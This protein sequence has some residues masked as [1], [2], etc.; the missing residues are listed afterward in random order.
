MNLFEKL[1][2]EHKL[3]LSTEQYLLNFGAMNMKTALEPYKNSIEGQGLRPTIGGI[4]RTY[5]CFDLRFRD[6]SHVKWTVKYDPDNLQQ[7]LAVSEDESLRFML[8]QK[9]EQPMALRDRQ[10]GDAEEL[11]RIREFNKN[12]ENKVIESLTISSEKTQQLLINNN[13]I[14]SKLSQL[15]ICDS[16]GQHKDRVSARRKKTQKR[17]IEDVNVIESNN[18]NV[19]IDDEKSIY[20]LY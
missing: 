10:A 6:Y 19:E 2:E 12:L 14:D 16:K 4:K 18:I 13:Q 15:L 1:P 8:E 7:I 20:D 11:T 9:Y 5:D 3:P 17:K